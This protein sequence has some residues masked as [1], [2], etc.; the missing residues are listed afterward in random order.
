MWA[1]KMSVYI[2]VWEVR[3]HVHET[4]LGGER[5]NS[6][7][8]NT[9]ASGYVR[10][11]GGRVD[12]TPNYHLTKCH[13][14]KYELAK[15]LYP[16]AKWYWPNSEKFNYAKCDWANSVNNKQNVESVFRVALQKY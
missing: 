4:S 5:M 1:K 16:Y 9:Q 12:I 13:Y 2:G 11:Y 7:I 15:Y 6:A 10:A 14:D 8:N 3:G